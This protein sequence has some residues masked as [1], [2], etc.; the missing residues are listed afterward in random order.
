VTIESFVDDLLLHLQNNNF[1]T[2]GVDLFI[3]GSDPEV[4][5]CI[6]IT[7]YEGPNPT[8]VKS[9]EDN[10]HCPNLQVLV[11]HKNRKQALETT[12]KIY[13]LWRRLAY[14]QIG[15]TKFE[16]ILA[17]GTWHPIGVDKANLM[18]FSINFSLKFE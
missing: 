9:G 4:E 12:I 16:Y 14:V 11:R 5:N 13:K 8:S 10:P 7:P 1:G 6:C 17:K 15:D 3:G 18:N 2:K